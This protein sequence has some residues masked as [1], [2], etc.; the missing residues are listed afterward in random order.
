MIDD[1]K[2]KSVSEAIR[3]ALDAQENKMI[4]SLKID[5]NEVIFLILKI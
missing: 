2:Y 4:P 1:E 5:K 3:L